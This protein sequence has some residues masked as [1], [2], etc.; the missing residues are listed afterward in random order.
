[1]KKVLLTITAI[2][3][4]FAYLI[5]QTTPDFNFETWNNIL[6]FGTPTSVQ[7]PQGW[8][9]LN[10]LNVVSSTPISV[11][12]DTTAPAEGAISVKITT[13]KVT[14]AQIPN[15][16]QAEDLD[17]AG[18]LAIGQIVTVPSPGIIY[19]FNYSWRPTVLSF[20]SK[21]T[22]MPGDSAYIVALLT[23]WNGLSRDTIASGIY[24]TGSTTTSY[25][26]NSLTMT[27]DPAFSTVS[28]DSQQVFISSSIYSH[29]GAQLGSAFYIDDLEWSGWNSVNDI[30]GLS[31]NISVY[32]NPATTTITFSSSAYAISTI[33]IADITGRLIGSYTATNNKMNIQTAGL[34]PGMYIYN[35]FNDKKVM[36]DRGRFEITR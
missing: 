21:Y 2:A 14:G 15:P 16:Y 33:E 13:V 28:P 30:N 4:S 29:N 27:Y 7:E 5:A 24:S 18:L 11:T 12:K 25:A 8:A 23:R 35:I 26:L 34:A 1:M 17:T 9:S 6:L 19:G 20:Q 22:P 10:T 32:P 36:V 3:S 31:G